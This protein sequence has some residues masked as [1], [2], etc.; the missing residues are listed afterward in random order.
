MEVTIEREG[1]VIIAPDGRT[2]EIPAATTLRKAL[3]NAIEPTDKALILDFESLSYISSAG[4]RAIASLANRTRAQGM[5]FVLC[6]LSKPVKVLFATSGFDNLVRVVDTVDDACRAA[7]E[8]TNPAPSP[9]PWAGW[10]FTL[11][12]AWWTPSRTGTRAGIRVRFT[13]L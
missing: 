1:S 9:C 7:G 11:S 12:A 4:L 10:G 3:E 6:S 5:V 8:Q 13:S 2:E